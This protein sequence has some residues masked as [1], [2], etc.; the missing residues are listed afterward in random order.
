GCCSDPRCRYRC[1]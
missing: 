1:R